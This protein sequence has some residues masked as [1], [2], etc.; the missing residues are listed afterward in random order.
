MAK[1]QPVYTKNSTWHATDEWWW[2]VLTTKERWR[3]C[4]HVIIT[5]V[6]NHSCAITE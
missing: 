1:Y 4:D 2:G 6:T 3:I 5:R